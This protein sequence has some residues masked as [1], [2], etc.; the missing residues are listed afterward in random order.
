MADRVLQAA[1]SQSIRD[2]AVASIREVCSYAN[3][4]PTW[5]DTSTVYG[6]ANLG[7]CDRV[8]DICAREKATSYTNL[9]GGRSLYDPECFLQRG[10]A[11]RFLA[12]VLDPYPQC[13]TEQF[14][15]G[16]SVLDLIM[17]TSREEVVRHLQLGRVSA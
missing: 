8:F 7:G 4:S 5:Q 12:P 14:I 13:R 6:N 10:I 15:P 11:L 1:N 2:V 3:L 16:M 9:P 17:N